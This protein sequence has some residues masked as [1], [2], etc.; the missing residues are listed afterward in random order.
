MIVRIRKSGKGVGIGDRQLG[1]LAYADDVVLMTE[2]MKDMK[3]LLEITRRKLW[4]GADLK[5]Q[6]QKT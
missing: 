4:E 6:C 5:F 2:N 3:E 1:C